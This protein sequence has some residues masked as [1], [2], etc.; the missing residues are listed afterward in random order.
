MFKKLNDFYMKSKIHMSIVLATHNEA[1][2]L[3]ACLE[4]VKDLAD[5][6][7]IVDGESTDGTPEL[8]TSL[9]A[10]VIAT[11]NKSN[12]HINKQMAMD[13][14]N[15]KLV[16]Q[17]DADEIV[18]AELREFI[19]GLKQQSANN[20]LPDQP[21]AWNLRRK[22]HLFGRW[23]SK[24]GQYPDPV[25]RLYI[26]GQA[27]LPQKDVHEQMQVDGDVATAPGHLLHYANPTFADYMRKFNTYTSFAAQQRF[28]QQEQLSAFSYLMVKPVVTF[29]SL[30]LRHRGY[31]DGMAGFVFALMSGLHH[32]FVYLKWWELAERERMAKGAQ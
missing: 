23:L 22:N 8:A 11:T 5:E 1:H 25:I 15:G 28:D 16:L 20:S 7:I 3:E 32:P 17:L 13:A 6:V 2:N 12:F 24:G 10:R 4:A 31:V 27:R 19:A 29:A 18:D 30:Y 14:A 21:V 9:G 26:N